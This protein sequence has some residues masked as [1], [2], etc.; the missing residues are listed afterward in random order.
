MLKFEHARNSR[1]SIMVL[2]TLCKK[3]PL[4]LFQDDLNLA[5]K[6]YYPRMTRALDCNSTL[7]AWLLVAEFCSNS[8][9]TCYYMYMYVEWR[10]DCHKSCM[11]FLQ[12][13]SCEQSRR[14]LISPI[15]LECRFMQNEF[16]QDPIKSTKCLRRIYTGF[17]EDE[18][19][20]NDELWKYNVFLLCQF[21]CYQLESYL[22]NHSFV[23]GRW[24]GY[25]GKPTN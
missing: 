2:H 12:Q 6:L 16:H 3:V 17:D 23:N 22:V 4:K 8:L 21:P 25:S 20:S 24:T 9:P 18:L 7:P 5:D 19:S 1:L 13:F 15:N 14:K 11:T 10:S